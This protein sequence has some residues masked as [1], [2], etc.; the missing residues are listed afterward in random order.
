MEN[1]GPP[2][3]REDTWSVN[4]KM[5]PILRERMEQEVKAEEITNAKNNFKRSL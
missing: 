5:E 4:N 3:P 1:A 2:P